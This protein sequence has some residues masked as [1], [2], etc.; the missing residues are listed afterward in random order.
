VRDVEAVTAELRVVCERPL[1]PNHEHRRHAA[2][3]KALVEL[4]ELEVCAPGEIRRPPGLAPKRWY[5]PAH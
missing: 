4:D 1:R 3:D 5:P 2:D